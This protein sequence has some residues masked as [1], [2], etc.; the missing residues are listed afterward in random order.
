M[1]ATNFD[2]SSIILLLLLVELSKKLLFLVL[3]EAD[4]TDNVFIPSTVMEEVATVFDVLIDV[5][6]DVA[7]AAVDREELWR[8]WRRVL[9]SI[10]E[11]SVEGV[12]S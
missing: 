12:T 10:G 3:A 6:F 11:A 8:C 5:D 7:E 4:L 1:F 9:S 2:E